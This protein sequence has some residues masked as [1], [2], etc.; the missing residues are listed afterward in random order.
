MESAD[1]E[2]GGRVEAPELEESGDLAD[3]DVAVVEVGAIRGRRWGIS[4]G[5]VSGKGG[6]LDFRRRCYRRRRSL[7]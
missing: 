2:Q 4:R 6:G 7:G 3:K 1:G 5:S